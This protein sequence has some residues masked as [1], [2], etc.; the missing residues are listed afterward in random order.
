MIFKT[1]IPVYLLTGF[2]G[3]GKTTFLNQ[4]LKLDGFQNSLVIVNEFG[5]VPIDH[6][7]VEE[8]TETIFELSNG[9][10]CCTIRG[11]LVETLSGL[12]LDRFDRI[13]IETTG[14]ADPLPVF[15]TLTTDPGISEKLTPMGI[16][17]V[18][19]LVRGRDLLNSHDEARR[20]IAVADTVVLTKSDYDHDREAALSAIRAINPS[21]G[22]QDAHNIRS[23]D[24]LPTAHTDRPIQFP[25]TSSSHSSRFRS[26]VLRV[27]RALPLSDLVGILH[28]IG[29]RYGADLLRIKGIASIAES[30]EPVVIQMSG[31]ILHEP[32]PAPASVQI[33]G[34]TTLVLITQ[35]SD[36]KFAVEMFMAFT[37]QPGIDHADRDAMMNNPLAIPG[38]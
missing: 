23:P 15:Q 19:D 36:P 11:E 33:P 27:P 16:L 31:Q 10:L 8:S 26:A 25:T 5:A 24:D 29:N 32:V 28:M 3:S 38:V 21:A 7:L 22:I 14:I 9:C 2:L 13:F 20:Q 37:G 35:D 30:K 34:G 18:H 17:S 1:K 4:L 6:L 12:E